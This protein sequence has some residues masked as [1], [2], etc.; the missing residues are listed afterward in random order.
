MSPPKPFPR[1]FVSYSHRDRRIRERLEIHLAPLKQTANIEIWTDKEIGAGE[2]WETAIVASLSQAT[3]A[4]LL[5]TADFLG[6]EFI[7]NKEIP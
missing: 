2:K 5:L 7:Q 4:V 1:L 6:S 3:I